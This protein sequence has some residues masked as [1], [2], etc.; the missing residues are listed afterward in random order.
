[1]T[2]LKYNVG[3]KVRIKK[4]FIRDHILVDSSY[5]MFTTP[6]GRTKRDDKQYGLFITAYMEMVINPNSYALILSKHWE[7]EECANYKVKFS[8][9][10]WEHIDPE[11]VRRVRVNE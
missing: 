9:G 2:M 6:G 7:G 4:S 3:D 1:M 8:N 11:N 10:Y 5:H